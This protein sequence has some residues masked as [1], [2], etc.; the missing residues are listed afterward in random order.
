MGST[1]NNAKIDA[2]HTTRL[3]ESPWSR[4]RRNARIRHAAAPTMRSASIT[5]MDQC[6]NLKGLVRMM[7]GLP[8]HRNPTNPRVSLANS[9]VQV[10]MATL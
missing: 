4:R 5:G 8:S 3:D 10:S 1:I 6:R 7:N 9:A 2:T